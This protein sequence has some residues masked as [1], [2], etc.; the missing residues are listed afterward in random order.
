M[1]CTCSP[2]INALKR[3]SR[4]IAHHV[5]AAA[6]TRD[7]RARPPLGGRDR[8]SSTGRR[9]RAHSP[10]CARE[11]AQRP[12]DLVINLQVYF[13][14]G[15]RHVVHARAGQARLRPR[16]RARLE[17]ALHHRPHPAAPDRQHVQ[18]QYFEFLSALGIAP[19]PVEWNLGPVAAGARLAARRSSRRIDRPIG[20]DRRGDEQAGEGLAARALGRSR[21]RAA[22]PT[23]ALQAGARRR[24]SRARTR[25]PN[26]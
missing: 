11:L 26:A 13:K 19:E 24:P 15:H 4:R 3:T 12:F 10:T 2:S 17:L 5:G 21:R 1:P 6:R 23:S 9:A 8:R 14:A 16:A 7:A 22:T 18:D 20:G 25:A